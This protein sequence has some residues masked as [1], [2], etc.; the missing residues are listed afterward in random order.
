MKRHKRKILVVLGL[1]AALATVGFLTKNFWRDQ[2][3]A[4]YL[5]QVEFAAEHYQ[6]LPKDIDTVEI[7][8]LSTNSHHADSDYKNG[9]YGDYNGIAG[10]LDHKTLTGTDAK[11][12]VK[13][14]GAFQIGRELQAMC[15]DPV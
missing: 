11:E 9:F 8:T 1:L 12:V 15:F 4:F 6:H 7:F 3:R 14:W 2:F 5:G 10:T 13:L